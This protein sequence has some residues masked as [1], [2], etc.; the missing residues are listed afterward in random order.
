MRT[1]L[2]RGGVA[3]VAAWMVSVMPTGL[4]AQTTPYVT[5]LDRA[6]D[7]LEVLVSEGLVRRIVLGE[8]PYSR[9]A[10]SRFVAEATARAGERESVSDRSRE[11]LERLTERFAD[12]AP[13]GPV[14]RP[15]SAHLEVSAARSP[16]RPLRVASVRDGSGIDGWVNPLLQLNQGR[17]LQDG[18]TG[19][20]ETALDLQWSR[21]AAQV[22][23]R[24]WLG[25]PRG[26]ED[27][28]A[29]IT[30]LEAHARSV[31]GPL[32]VELGRNHVAL[33][34]GQ[35]GG[36]H[37]TH[38]A[39]GLDMVRLSMDRPAQLPGPFRVLGLWQLSGLLA[40][41]GN[42][43]DIP[44]SYLTVLRLSSRPTRFT[45]LALNY[46]NHQGGEGSP[47][48]NWRDRIHD[49]FFFWTN[50]GYLQIS[51]KLL[52]FDVAVTI[53]AIHSKLYVNFMTTDDRGRFSQPA[54]GIWEDAIWLA[55]ARVFRVGPS[56]RFDL[57]GEWRHSGA[58]AHSH[59]QF[60]SGLTLDG[61]V[62]GDLLGPNAAA[63]HGGIDWTGS[64]SRVG[65]AVAWERYSGD[66]Y[67]WGIPEGDVYPNWDWWRLADNPD[68]IR[69]RVTATWTPVGLSDEME[70]S[71]RL[72]YEHVQRFAYGD[73]TRS[74][75]FAQVA[76]GYSW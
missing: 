72:G 5:N 13:D 68:E 8:R 41:M 71:V 1:I 43:R 75:V 56:G 47:R 57:W 18:F 60:T 14:L 4:D 31:F 11:A 15:R 63:V 24:A 45:E 38:N 9:A 53:P 16:D 76:V 20:F 51:D 64:A 30:L 6:Y 48:G 70:A 23:P 29:D 65:V 55:G 36:A 32:S 22:R 50:D 59:H 17:V 21:V 10:F 67:T 49:T 37:L 74:N 61:R 19:A 25:A 54:S 7:D 27:L 42:N 26:P 58:R 69:R 44:G 12:P 28:D 33:G 52:G 46:M 40:N 66:D 34:H 73:E 3:A 39:R 2:W 62:I 35:L